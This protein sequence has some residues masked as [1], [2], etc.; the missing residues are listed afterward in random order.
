M[1]RNYKC[2]FIFLLLIAACSSQ[3]QVQDNAAV[4]TV[5]LEQ[6]RLVDALE[7]LVKLSETEQQ[8]DSVR[9]LQI[10]QYA[11]SAC[12]TGIGSIND[13]SLERVIDKVN[14]IEDI[15]IPKAGESVNNRLAISLKELQFRTLVQTQ[16]RMQEIY[17]NPDIGDN[18]GFSSDGKKLEAHGKYLFEQQVSW[19]LPLLQAKNRASQAKTQILYDLLQSLPTEGSSQ[20]R[21]RIWLALERIFADI[22]LL[23]SESG[24]AP[25]QRSAAGIFVKQNEILPELRQ[26][27]EQEA[28]PEIR[29]IAASFITK[30][31]KQLAELS[32]R[33]FLD[34]VEESRELQ[35][36]F[37]ENIS[38]TASETHPYLT[39]SA[40]FEEGMNAREDSLKIAYFSKAIENNPKL[41]A[42]YNNRGNIYKEQGHYQQGLQDYNQVVELEPEFVPGYVNRANLLQQLG[43]HQRAIELAPDCAE[44]YYNLG[45]AYWG[46]KQWHL[47]IKAWKD[48]LR[49]NPNHQTV[50]EWLPKAEQ[51]ARSQHY[52]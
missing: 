2:T 26:Q 18:G 44:A 4:D 36:S 16:K 40:L 24:Y 45:R 49:I 41:A 51:A 3:Q 21:K 52:R 17:E 27:M 42:A 32:D 8:I 14:R 15:T 46:I 47:V 11:D 7:Y 35:R 23:K 28:D 30:I 33:N 37:K 1:K 31:E 39:A 10:I 29:E 13:A 9:A 43:N 50:K 48:C 22:D 6:R 34:R 25:F 19:M 5:I 20:E 38:T 12:S